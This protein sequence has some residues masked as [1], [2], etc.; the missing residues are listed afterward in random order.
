M[1]IFGVTWVYSGYPKKSYYM[2]DKKY[3]KKWDLD[4]D[5]FE[6]F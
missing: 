1:N 4:I 2:L 5:R 3:S 6:Y